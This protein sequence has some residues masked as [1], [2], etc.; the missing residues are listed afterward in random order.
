[1][2]LLINESFGILSNGEIRQEI[3][4]YGKQMARETKVK[5]NLLENRL[6]IAEGNVATNPNNGGKHRRTIQLSINVHA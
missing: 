4:K 6:K 5:L 1:M 3:M 2:T